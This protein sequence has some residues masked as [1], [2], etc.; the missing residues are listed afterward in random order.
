[1]ED[2]W[3]ALPDGQFVN[4]KLVIR[5]EVQRDERRAGAPLSIWLMFL[6]GH[7]TSYYDASHAIIV[8]YLRSVAVNR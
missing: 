1:M 6:D 5:A 8:E 4:M 3:L 2:K 7:E